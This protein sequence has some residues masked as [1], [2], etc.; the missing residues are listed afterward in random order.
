M[1]VVETVKIPS[2]GS[3]HRFLVVVSGTA[4]QLIHHRA[5]QP[6]APSA[7]WLCWVGSRDA[8]GVFPST[9]PPLWGALSLRAADLSQD[10][11]GGS[12]PLTAGSVTVEVT[13]CQDSIQA[14]RDVCPS[15]F[16]QYEEQRQNVKLSTGQGFFCLPVW[17]NA[18]HQG[19][20]FLC[21]RVWSVWVCTW[22]L[23]S[24]F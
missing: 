16:L 9:E 4:V 15:Q 17:P 8:L 2:R 6:A 21:E 13:N 24:Y 14:N 10:V 5:C 23:Q 11:P 22:V 20:R 7:R 3:L 1:N 12:C 18:F 19:Q